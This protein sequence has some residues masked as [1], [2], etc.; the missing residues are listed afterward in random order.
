[1][2][3]RCVKLKN[4]ITGEIQQRSAWLTIGK[5]YHVLSLFI[6]ERRLLFARII[7][8]DGNT[9]G[10]YDMSQF[11]ILDATIPSNWA[12][13]SESNIVLRL[14]P[15]KWQ[16]Q[17]FWNLFFDGDPHAR[18]VFEEEKAVIVAAGDQRRFTGR[19][20]ANGSAREGE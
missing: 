11:E 3:V 17:G 9:P 20:A 18:K 13:N 5:E 4:E 7:G 19:V 8:D 16:S 12:A 10:I 1:M 6:D 15:E 2:K 14:G